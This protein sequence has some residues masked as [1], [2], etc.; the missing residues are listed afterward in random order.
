MARPMPWAAPGDDHGAGVKS[1]LHAFRSSFKVSI[2]C[3]RRPSSTSWMR[4]TSRSSAG[5][6]DALL[7][8]ERA[9]DP[10][11]RVDLGLALAHRK[12]APDA[13]MGLRRSAGVV[14][15]PGSDGER[16]G[17]GR[18]GREGLGPEFAE[19]ARGHAARLRDRDH[20]PPEREPGR[21]PRRIGE[22][23]RHR[24]RRERGR[25]Q[26]RAI[27]ELAPEIAPDVVGQHRVGLEE[28][29]K[30]VHLARAL[31]DRAVDLARPRPRRGCR[32]GCGPGPSQSAP[33]LTKQPMV[34]LGP[35]PL[36]DRD[37]VQPVLGREDDSRPR[38]DAGASAS[39]ASSVCCAFTAS[40]MRLKP[41]VISSGVAAGMTS[42]E[43]V[44]RPLDRKPGGAAGLDVLGVLVDEQHVDAGP[45]PIGPERAA[46]RAGAPDQD[47]LGHGPS[48][49]SRVSSTPARQS[50]S[51]TS[52]GFW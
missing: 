40:T 19:A 29:E 37:L 41:P 35:D 26:H 50:S 33:K 9:D 28:L 38:R 7:A 32:R 21:R 51:I 24:V 3:L 15:E 17:L 47:R 23:R 27:G 45:R 11:L 20:L 31:A 25:E 18:A 2:D 30:R 49:A 43:A 5:R 13:G 46:D 12:V 42:L 22:V 36:R 10:D 14:G 8:R 1:E 34:A 48:S 16:L 52:S 4:A 44:D 39:S 6:R